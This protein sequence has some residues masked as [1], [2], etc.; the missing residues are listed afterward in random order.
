[1]ALIE[2]RFVCDLSKPVQ[3][4]VLKGNVFSL[5]NL[6][7]RLS[8]LIY[9]NGQPATISGTITG[10]CILPDGSTVN[11][12]GGLTSENESSKAYVDVP[13]SCLLIPGILKIAI[14]CTSSSVITTLAA[15]VANVYMTK[16]D[17]VI[18]PSQQVITDWNAEITA[19]LAN[20]NAEISVLK[21]AL[22]QNYANFIPVEQ[23]YFA[24]ADGHKEGSSDW[25]RTVEYVDR[26]FIVSTTNSLMWLLAFNK[27]T[28]EYIGAWNGTT[29]SMTYDS[30]S[31]KRRFDIS[32][33]VKNYPNYIFA[34]D[35]KLSSVT[36]SIIYSD[37]TIEY[38]VDKEAQ[39]TDN[40][41]DSFDYS[42]APNIFDNNFDQSGYINPS[43]G[44][45]ASGSSYKRTSKYYQMDTLA[46]CL[47]LKLSA[48][49]ST[50][51]ILFY[52][53]N[54]NYLNYYFG[55]SNLTNATIDNIPQ[56]SQYFRIYTDSSYASSCSISYTEQSTIVPYKGE[57]FVKEK[58]I[59][60]SNFADGIRKNVNMIESKR[61]MAKTYMNYA[62]GS[63][64]RNIDNYRTSSKIKVDAATSYALTVFFPEGGNVSEN[65]SISSAFYNG[66]SYI[67]G[68]IHSNPLT[69]PS[70]HT[71]KNGVIKFTTPA[72]T[73]HIRICVSDDNN[74]LNWQLQK[75]DGTPYASFYQLNDDVSGDILHG[76]EGKNIAVFGD[77][78]IGNTRNLTAT[79]AYI[80]RVSKG[81]VFNLGFGGCRMSQHSGNWDLCSMYRLA[82]MINTGDFSSLVSA[83]GT[84]W[85]GM[86]GYFETTAVELANFI[87]FS[88][89]DAIVIAYGTNDYRDASTFDNA[90]NKYDCSTVLGA[91]RYSIKKIQE[92]YPAIRI[93]VSCPVYRFF[94][95]NGEFAYDSDTKDWGTG[96]LEDYSDGFRSVCK[97]M[98][99]QFYDA[100]HDSQLSYFTRSLYFDS[101][102][103]THPNQYGRKQLGT[104]LARELQKMI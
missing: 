9:D 33:Y 6:G 19:N 20:Q 29:F 17:N 34:I 51:I 65:I 89:I 49:V 48:S 94:L 73:T 37:L 96:T 28:G 52:D 104:V 56:D 43:T 80:G 91:L 70:T 85:S 100:Y 23:G 35:F 7:S 86:P 8:V 15:I 90:E 79:P 30:S 40:V 45:D 102:D 97:E 42:S 77:S 78:I 26:N 71:C 72:N 61:I 3:A 60:E 69:N 11:I 1:M 21:S 13:Q 47:Y 36:P 32:E 84:G 67:S 98:K 16:T 38:T 76:L 59:S 27:F 81:N 55:A 39:R 24:I 18:T 53:G 64:Y 87:D 12:S 14:K 99:V 83:T 2:N 10:N 95:S 88:K 63:V 101:D 62:N 57:L 50:F 31:W 68:I 58:E 92:A 93:L 82:E 46:P 54:K 44:A 75:T 22:K 66:D 25:C 103:G 74:P 4:Q 5:D 41:F